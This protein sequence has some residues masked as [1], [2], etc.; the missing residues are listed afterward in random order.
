MAI[1]HGVIIPTMVMFT[2]NT[3]YQS[4]GAS[5]L[6]P[7][8]SNGIAISIHWSFLMKKDQSIVSVML[9]LAQQQARM[10][11]NGQCNIFISAQWNLV[12]VVAD[13]FFND[14]CVIF[15]QSPQGI[16]HMKIYPWAL[17]V[18]PP[19]LLPPQQ[20]SLK[21]MHQNGWFIY[22]AK[23]EVLQKISKYLE[24]KKI[25]TKTIMSSKASYMG[26]QI[27]CLRSHFCTKT[28]LMGISML[29]ST[30]T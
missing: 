11:S 25:C 17:W 29:H 30:C 2:A 21:C 4:L 15:T 27:L 3:R 1:L 23:K 12:S 10:K 18:V 7:R 26:L 6:L 8:L 9:S 24:R 19:P 5:L 13:N 16:D 22:N 28:I 20:A 14:T